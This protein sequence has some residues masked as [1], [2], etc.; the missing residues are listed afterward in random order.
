[1]S[2]P[3]SGSPWFRVGNVWVLRTDGNG[4]KSNHGTVDFVDGSIDF[5]EV[6]GV[7]DDLVTSDNVLREL[8][9]LF[10]PQCLKSE[11]AFWVAGK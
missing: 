10:T 2:R 7:G 6:V 5:L 11:R 8:S 1:M 3:L 4:S 9:A